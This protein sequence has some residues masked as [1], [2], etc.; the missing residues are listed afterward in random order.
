VL[1]EGF[2][3]AVHSFK[4]SVFFEVTFLQVGLLQSL[5]CR[6]NTQLTLNV[7]ILICSFYIIKSL[8]KCME[9]FYRLLKSSFLELLIAP[10]LFEVLFFYFLLELTWF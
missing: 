3:S 1:G 7:V 5:R 9:G 8:R 10:L 2:I 4:M 6:A